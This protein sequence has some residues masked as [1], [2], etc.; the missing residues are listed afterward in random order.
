MATALVIWPICRQNAMNVMSPVMWHRITGVIAKDDISPRKKPSSTF[1]Q[2]TNSGKHVVNSFWLENFQ[3]DSSLSPFQ[4]TLYARHTR[5]FHISLLSSTRIEKLHTF[6][7]TSRTLETWVDQTGGICMNTVR[8]QAIWYTRISLPIFI[9]TGLF[10]VALFN[11][12][13]KLEVWGTTL[14]SAVAWINR[15]S[16]KIN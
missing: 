14:A 12:I 13:Q 10:S 11:N 4:I 9:Q 6:Q 16:A 15:Y 5:W 8:I 2:K 1:Y 7:P 3:R